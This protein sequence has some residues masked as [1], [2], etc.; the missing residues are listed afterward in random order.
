MTEQNVEMKAGELIFFTE[1]SYSD[2]NI[3]GTFVAL[4]NVSADEMRALE[5]E[6]NAM[7]S[8][9]RP[10]FVNVAIARGWLVSVNAREIWLGDYF[11]GYSL[12]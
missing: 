9:T 1:G 12:A 6:L 11:G 7:D 4:Q 8:E 10:L 5:A 3:Q 2:Y